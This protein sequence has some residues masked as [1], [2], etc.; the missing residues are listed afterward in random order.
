MAE[1]GPR[2]RKLTGDPPAGE[3][4]KRAAEGGMPSAQ[5]E[6][7]GALL[8]EALDGGPAPPQVETA[9]A[10]PGE[11]VDET[12]SLSPEAVMEETEFEKEVTIYEPPPREV[13][14]LVGGV[15]PPRPIRAI[16]NVR[17]EPSVAL[18]IQEPDQ[19]VNLLELPDRELTEAEKAAILA[20]LGEGR[21][22]ELQQEVEEA[23]DEIRRRMA[24]NEAVSTEAYNKLLK[25]QDIL[26]RRDASKLAQAEYYL[27]LVHAQL[28]RV[29]AS[30]EA[31]QRYQ[32]PLFAWGFLWSAA[33]LV[34]MILMGQEWFQKALGS[35]GQ[36]GALLDTETF[37]ASMLWGGIGGAVAVLYSLFKH[38][39]ERDFDS[40]Y[41]LSY[42]GKPF[43]G[44]VVGGTVY[45][46]FN[47]VIR[48]L[49]IFPAGVP[50]AEGNIVP[51]VAP[52]VVYLVAWASGFKEDRILELVDA[53]MKRIFASLG[54]GESAQQADS[55][56]AGD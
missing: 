19:K 20:H 15:L 31:A 28:D 23:Y 42:V 32:W 51:T 54:S 40:Q 8:A 26:L 44:L 45:M 3:E 2:F 53:M 12:E 33:F 27:E 17:L 25:A 22:Q 30:E 43:L 9:A 1:G 29:S 24:S 21:I 16:L 49:G 52:G 47:L 50:D 13:N 36:S 37:L 48:A 34:T 4:I 10:Q 18:D 7:D 11:P 5:D 6:V 41:V 55:G 39:G 56:S 35:T 14:D 38:V 46:V